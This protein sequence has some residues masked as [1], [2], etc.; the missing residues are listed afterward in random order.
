MQQGVRAEERQRLAYLALR[1][2]S[3]QLSPPTL[4][5]H[6]NGFLATIKDIS[7]E[8]EKLSILQSSQ[9]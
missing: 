2:M 9:L 7:K 6:M 5:L 8:L 4:G 3:L 1:A